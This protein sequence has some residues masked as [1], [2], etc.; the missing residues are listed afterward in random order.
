MNEG[1][2]QRI[3]I[4]PHEA[5]HDQMPTI[6]LDIIEEIPLVVGEEDE[7]VRPLGGRG[8]AAGDQ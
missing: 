1:Q 4:L 2:S 6:D 8:E 7:H 3:I 5:A